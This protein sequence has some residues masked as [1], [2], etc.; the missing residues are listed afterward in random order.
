MFVLE[1][2]VTGFSRAKAR[3]QKFVEVL[4][5][6]SSVRQCGQRQAVRRV[7]ARRKVFYLFLFE[8]Q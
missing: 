6:P 5:Q 8:R 2:A 4:R 3:V 1:E 7:A